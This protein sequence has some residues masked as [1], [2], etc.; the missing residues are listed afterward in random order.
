MDFILVLMCLCGIALG[1]FSSVPVM[2]RVSELQSLADDLDTDLA[3]LETDVSDL[4][5][6]LTAVESQLLS[7]R[8][9]VAMP[10]ERMYSGAELD[11]MFKDMFANE[12]EIT[13]AGDEI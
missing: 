5:K 4:M 7:M 9:Q 8:A 2:E 1:I 6:R 3:D 13:E 12:V 10:A 11:R